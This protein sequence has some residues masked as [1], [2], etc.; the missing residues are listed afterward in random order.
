MYC[1]YSMYTSS[2]L[3]RSI[4]TIIFFNCQLSVVHTVELN[5]Y[6]AFVRKRILNYFRLIKGR[7]LLWNQKGLQITPSPPSP[8]PTHTVCHNMSR[9]SRAGRADKDVITLWN[10]RHKHKDVGGGGIRKRRQ[11]VKLCGVVCA[12]GRGRGGIGGTVGVAVVTGEVVLVV[13]A[14]VNN[15]VCVGE[16]FPLKKHHLK[17]VPRFNFQRYGMIRNIV[18]VETVEKY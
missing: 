4:T 8:R 5:C 11:K 2:I 14:Q 16:F 3:L 6:R 7:P 10:T 15:V 9:Q 13:S 17:S 12:V 1:M 18:F